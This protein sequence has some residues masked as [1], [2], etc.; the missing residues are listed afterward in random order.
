MTQREFYTA[1]IAAAISDEMTDHAT[2]E[3]AKL[4]KRNATP[5]KAEREKAEAN[6]L[7]KA[8]IVGILTALDEGEAVNAA[9]IAE[10]VGISVQKASALLRQICGDGQAVQSEAKIK[11]KGKVKGYYIA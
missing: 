8:Q 4:D 11:G 7:L 10:T 3:I 1:V 5:S 6:E 9:Y 2:A